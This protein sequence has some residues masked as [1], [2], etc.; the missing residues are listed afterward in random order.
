MF[1]VTYI[2]IKH[3]TQGHCNMQCM[4]LYTLRFFMAVFLDLTLERVAQVT[5]FDNEDN[6]T[7]SNSFFPLIPAYYKYV[8]ICV[9]SSFIIYF[10]LSTYFGE[11]KFIQGNVLDFHHNFSLGT[12]LP[13]L[14]DQGHFF[15]F[16][17]FIN[18]SDKCQVHYAFFNAFHYPWSQT[19]KKGA[20]LSVT[21]EFSYLGISMDIVKGHTCIFVSMSNFLLFLRLVLMLVDIR[22]LRDLSSHYF[23][24][25]LKLSL[26]IPPPPPITSAVAWH[27]ISISIT[28]PK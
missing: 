8:S 16:L 21:Y 22:R 10:R 25:C 19:D 11:R 20:V 6:F 18:C 3:N 9:R 26:E 27:G 7:I 4:F 12:M 28:T 23:N 1:R 24:L 17:K 15:L 2:H 5:L 14:V 13:F